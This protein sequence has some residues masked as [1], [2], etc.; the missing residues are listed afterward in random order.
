MARGIKTGVI[1]CVLAALFAPAADAQETRPFTL[2][3]KL[4]A[5]LETSAQLLARGGWGAEAEELVG[6]MKALGYGE[7]PADKLIKLCKAEAKGKK[8]TP[9]PAVIKSLKASVHQLAGAIPP[10]APETRPSPDIRAAAEA[11]LS[12]DGSI[13]SLHRMLGEEKTPAGWRTPEAVAAESRRKEIQDALTKARR[14]PV[15]IEVSEDA[16]PV[17]KE[18]HGTPCN[19]V[20]AHGLTLWSRWSPEKLSRVARESLRALAVS[21]YLVKGELRIPNVQENI[22]ILDA[23]NDYDRAIEIAKSRG[24]IDEKGYEQAKVMA[25]FTAPRVDLPRYNIDFDQTEAAAEATI[26]YV[27]AYASGAYYFP[28]PLR[29]GHVNWVCLSYLGTSMPSVAWTETVGEK[30]Q[31]RT[32]AGVDP[33]D[34]RKQLLRLAEAGIAGSRSWLKWMAAHGEDPPFARAILDQDG[35]IE[36]DDRLKCTFVAEFLQEHREL[37]TLAEKTVLG[38]RP[39]FEEALGSLAAFEA[40][41]RRWLL[42]ATPSLVERLDPPKPRVLTAGEIDV[43]ARLNEHRRRCF[44]GSICGDVEPGERG[45]WPTDLVE[46]YLEVTLDDGLSD[47]TR[48]HASYLAKNPEQMKAWPDAHEEW[49]DRP[50]FTV[51][52]S[53]AGLRSVIVP[54]SRSPES[55]LNAWLGTFYH[56]LPLIHPGLVRIG[57]ALSD[58]IAVLDCGSLARPLPGPWHVVWPY[59]GMTDV[60]TH[61]S[62]PEL[63]NPVPGADQFTFGYPVTLQIGAY[64]GQGEPRTITIELRE[65][66]G[67]G[68]VVACHLSTPSAPSNPDCAPTDAWCLI[69]KAP[70][71]PSTVYAVSAKW[72]TAKWSSDRKIAWSFKTR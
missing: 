6:R 72:S 39:V 53:L 25:N 17:I 57:W 44:K 29:V 35:K 16:D 12:I 54:G 52:G 1:G 21:H 22:L 62:A 33:T 70:L 2:P 27:S 64:L 8:R 40:R 41:W 61:F 63:P 3:A 9:V 31:R 68:P 5:P 67:N 32:A 66:D 58:G 49:P 4:L 13:E 10:P 34:E 23:R 48:K 50:E 19:R 47:G 38:V 24:W 55:A 51:E 69:P 11:V 37:V 42:G 30:R 14:L 71:K 59:D 65:K 43:L 36:G 46:P 7:A 18:I 60:P 56:R 15:D 26:V 28:P 45:D 20:S